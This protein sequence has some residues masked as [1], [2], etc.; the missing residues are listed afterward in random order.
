[1]S[2]ETPRSVHEA[3]EAAFNAGDLE[4]IVALYEPNAIL[5]SESGKAVRGHDA[6]REMLQKFLA[7]S[8]KLTLQIAGC[9][10]IDEIALLSSEWQLSGIDTKGNAVQLAGQ[11]ADVVRRQS[12]GSWRIIIDN[13]WAG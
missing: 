10:Q 1:M 12:N 6:V 11:M 4:K 9:F 2:A 5:V 8:Q 7:V 13:L 3:F